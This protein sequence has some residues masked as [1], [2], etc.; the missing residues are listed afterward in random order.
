MIGK[1]TAQMELMMYHPEDLIPMGHLLKQVDRLVSFE[2]VY[3]LV[4]GNYSEKGR[5]SIDPVCLIKIY[6]NAYLRK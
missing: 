5:P 1:K 6:L 3:D 2:F 4:K